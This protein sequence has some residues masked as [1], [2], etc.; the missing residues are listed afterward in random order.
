M[1][2]NR[3]SFQIIVRALLLFAT[4]IVW[5]SIFLR[6]DLIFNQLILAFVTTLQLIGLIRFVSK[7]NNELSR[8]L[9]SIRDTDFTARFSSYNEDP[10]FELLNKS[11]GDLISKLG[12]TE[13]EKSAHQEYLD[14]L[15][16]RSGDTQDAW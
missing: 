15:S 11:F 14:F 3:F 5:A 16:E 4:L 2:Y 8:F 9:D 6:I 10:S 7:T 1:V 12:E 13:T